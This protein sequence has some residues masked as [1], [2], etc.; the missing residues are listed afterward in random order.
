MRRFGWHVGDRV[1]L[2]GSI[3]PVVAILTVVG[4]SG[5]KGISNLVVFAGIICRLSTTPMRRRFNLDQGGPQ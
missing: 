2:R 3:Y 4:T 5:E 1:L